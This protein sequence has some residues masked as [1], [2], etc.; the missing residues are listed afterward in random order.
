LRAICVA[1]LVVALRAEGAEGAVVSAVPWVMADTMFEY[2]LR[3][4]AASV[5]RTR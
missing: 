3:L 2:G 1:E 4:P 5:A